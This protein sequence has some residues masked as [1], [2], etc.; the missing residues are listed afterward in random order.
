M[1]DADEGID[2]INKMQRFWLNTKRILAISTKPTRKEF[3]QTVK[4]C[5]VA[6]SLV[7]VLSFIIQIIAAL[8]QPAPEVT[9]T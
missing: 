3:W 9:S 6:L 8:V 4:I 2:T 7:G 1:S 5:T